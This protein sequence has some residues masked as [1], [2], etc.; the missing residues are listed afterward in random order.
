[1]E[2]HKINKPKLLIV[3]DDIENQRFLYLFLKKYFYVDTTDSSDQFYQ[4]IEQK[5]YDVFIMDIAIRGDKD[6]LELTRELKNSSEYANTPV[7]CYTAHA[8]HTDRINAL[9]AG[10]DLYLT[11]P[12]DIRTLLHSLMT[13]LKKSGKEVAYDFEEQRAV[14]L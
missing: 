13:L 7:L 14:N 8:F 10:S 1:M 2:H 3:E 4:L 12:S 9:N 6:G 5:K 11:K